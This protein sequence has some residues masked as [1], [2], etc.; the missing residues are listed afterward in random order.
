MAYED[1]LRLVGELITV[2]GA[3]VILVLEVSETAIQFQVS[4]R[5]ILLTRQTWICAHY[6][7]GLICLV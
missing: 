1:E 2:I 6:L 7:V 5:K 4:S 3:V